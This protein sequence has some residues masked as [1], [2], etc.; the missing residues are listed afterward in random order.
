MIGAFLLSA[1]LAG[2]PT[3]YVASTGAVVGTVSLPVSP[4][5][6]LTFVSDPI[7]TNRVAGGSTRVTLVE[8]QGA[9]MVLDY[10]SPSVIADVHYRVRQCPIA[11]GFESNLIESDSFSQYHAHYTLTPEGAGTLLRYEVAMTVTLW[12]PKSLVE[13]TT[14]REVRKMMGSFLEHFTGGS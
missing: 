13:Q 7:A 12:V 5:K 1:A 4:D 2:E 3:S 6:V 9:C 11:G 14:K 8:Q 10:L